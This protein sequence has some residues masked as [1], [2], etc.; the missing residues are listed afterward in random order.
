[1]AAGRAQ[2]MYL[3][4]AGTRIFLCLGALNASANAEAAQ[5]TALRFHDEGA[6]SSFCWV[7]Q[8]FGYALSGDCHAGTA[9]A[10]HHRVPAAE[11]CA[12]GG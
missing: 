4:A 9:G 2:F 7:D 11:C 5:A 10:G 1:M 12:A 8:G 6:V 3:N